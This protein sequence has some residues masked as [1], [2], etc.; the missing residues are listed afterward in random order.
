VQK[1]LT[2]KGAKKENPNGSFATFAVLFAS[3]AVRLFA[4]LEKA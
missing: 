2:A 3:F 4:R 1:S